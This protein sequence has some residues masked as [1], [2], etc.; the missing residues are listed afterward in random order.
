M[1]ADF[2][3]ALDVA[4]SAYESN[5]PAAALKQLDHA[6]NAARKRGDEQQLERVLEFAEGVIARDERTKIGRQN[7]LYAVRQN[8]RQATRKRA[9]AAGEPWVDPYP[10][11]ESPREHTRTFISRG[12]KF[13]I[14]VGVLFAVVIAAAFVAAIIV[15][16]LSSGEAELALRI[17]N[18]TAKRVDVKWCEEVSCDVYDEP[19]S[20][21]HL[22][23]G[24]YARRDLPASDVVD[25]FVI[26]NAAGHRVGCLPVR[27]DRTYESLADKRTVVA[28]H[29]SDATPCPGEIVT[30]RMPL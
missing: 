17:R 19:Y 18:D 26:E 15:G 24:E 11:L 21:M 12:V 8:L 28:V 22:D 13:W 16:G 6:R 10:D 25:L 9:L 5:D 14:A 30:P 29:V 2:E 3:R 20:T 1:P 27:V 4:R 23:P 7:L